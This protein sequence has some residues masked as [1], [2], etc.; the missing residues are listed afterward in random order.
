MAV[1]RQDGAE[2][3]DR[4]QVASRVGGEMINL[5]EQEDLG[6]VVAKICQAA[7]VNPLKLEA[8]AEVVAM[9]VLQQEDMELV[10]AMLLEGKVNIDRATLTIAEF[11]SY[12]LHIILYHEFDNNR[13][14]DWLR[15]ASWRR[16]YEIWW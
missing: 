4:A 2:Q 1:T 15:A 11:K 14:W 7:G 5:L 8:T 12:K 13:L 16:R 10:A 3:E 6:A 9:I